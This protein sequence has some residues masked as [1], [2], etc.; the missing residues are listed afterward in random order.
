MTQVLG[1]GY[2]ASHLYQWQPPDRCFSSHARP[3][4][5]WLCNATFLSESRWPHREGLHK[6]KF[7][8]TTSS[9]THS[10]NYIYNYIAT[11]FTFSP[12]IAAVL[13]LALQNLAQPRGGSS[14]TKL[15]NTPSCSINCSVCCIG[16]KL[17][18]IP[19]TLKNLCYFYRITNGQGLS[20]RKLLS[21][22][23]SAVVGGGVWIRYPSS[24]L[25]LYQILC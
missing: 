13:V 7:K 3:W 14:D 1:L 24:S 12:R 19:S 4:G 18:G 2:T 16:I 5:S 11:S 10:I 23:R 22:A 21:S 9:I 15:E 8:S 17:V 6:S 25:I 20:T